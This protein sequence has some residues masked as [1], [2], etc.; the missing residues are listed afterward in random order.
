LPSAGCGPGFS[1]G[2][3][4]ADCVGVI[5][6]IV[7]QDITFAEVVCQHIGFSA[8]SNLAAGQT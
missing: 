4:G 2:R 1:L 8:V 7:K 3:L 6:P 5:T